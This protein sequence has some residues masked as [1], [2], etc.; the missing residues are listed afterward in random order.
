MGVHT[1]KFLNFKGNGKI[2]LEDR[3]LMLKIYINTINSKA[4]TKIIKQRVMAN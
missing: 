3:L 2:L 4:N 1:A